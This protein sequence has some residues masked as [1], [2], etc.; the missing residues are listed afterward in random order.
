MNQ[1]QFDVIV[2]IIK[3]GAPALADELVGALVNLVNAYNKL[4]EEH[5]SHGSTDNSDYTLVPGTE[6]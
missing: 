3:N 5:E 6:E 2:A 4:K 1:M